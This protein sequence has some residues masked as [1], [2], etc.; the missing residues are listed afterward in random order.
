MACSWLWFCLY[1]YWYKL[2][3]WHCW[4]CRIKLTMPC[5]APA[6]K[7]NIFMTS[8][9]TFFFCCCWFECLTSLRGIS[10]CSAAYD[11]HVMSK[12]EAAA[13]SSARVCVFHQSLIEIVRSMSNLCIRSKIDGRNSW[14][15]S[16][17]MI[18]HVQALLACLAGLL[19]L[20]HLESEFCSF[21]M[22]RML[23]KF[24]MHWV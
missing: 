18:L 4:P 24:I 19:F 7:P 14:L 3:E 1:V 15:H 23:S 20:Q 2:K 8:W 13:N 9:N 22:I 6:T 5:R 21:K 17:C 10:K 11:P 16:S 12:P